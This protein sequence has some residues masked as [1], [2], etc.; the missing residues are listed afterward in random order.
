MIFNYLKYNYKGIKIVPK[1]L[2]V[3]I[4][5]DRNSENPIMQKPDIPNI[6]VTSTTYLFLKQ[7]NVATGSSMKKYSNKFINTFR[8]SYHLVRL[9]L[10]CEIQLLKN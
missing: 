6:I 5:R 9:F 3:A 4:Q 1:L 8:H 10:I 7:T 2:D